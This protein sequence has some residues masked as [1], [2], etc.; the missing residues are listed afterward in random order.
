MTA[1]RTACLVALLCSAVV[2]AQAPAPEPLPPPPP[3]PP[4]DFAPPPLPAEE[5][6]PAPPPAQPPRF[7]LH[8]EAGVPDG[9]GASIV[10]SPLGFLRLE[11]GWLN[12]GV[13]NGGRAGV[14]LVAFATAF[15]RPL[16]GVD[17]GAV[18]GGLGEWLPDL[19]PDQTVRNVVRGATVKFVNAQVGF[20]LGSRNVALTVHLGGA[21]VD[22]ALSQQA[23][24]LNPGAASSSSVSGVMLKAFLP[25]ARLGLLVAFG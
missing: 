6:V 3:M 9:I 4:T 7:G 23:L 1:P 17:A 24:V 19:I 18:L 2:L 10:V 11:A 12:N 22:V 20:E 21:Y 16:F 14:T 25:S 5:A 15:V 8:L 13:G